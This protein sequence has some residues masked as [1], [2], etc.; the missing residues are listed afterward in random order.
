MI[1]TSG[2]TGVATLQAKMGGKRKTLVIKPIYL[3]I[4]ASPTPSTNF[5]VTFW[6]FVA[7]FCPFVLYGGPQPHQRSAHRYPCKIQ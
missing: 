5:I 2:P 7:Q 6:N 1:F 4:Y 3:S